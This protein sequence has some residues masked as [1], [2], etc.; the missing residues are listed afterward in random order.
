MSFSWRY[1][2]RGCSCCR[3]A[4]KRYWRNSVA[5][6]LMTGQP[7]SDSG[8]VSLPPF[9]PSQEI[10]LGLTLNMAKP[11]LR[12]LKAASLL[13][14]SLP[15]VL[16]LL[17]HSLGP[18]DPTFATLLFSLASYQPYAS[19]LRLVAYCFTSQTWFSLPLSSC[20]SPSWLL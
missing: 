15:K 14:S 11:L 1:N 3:N 18:G 6:E 19:S 16:P 13:V 9:R 7:L 17:P 10:P 5:F 8:D 4:R 12:V 2:E 20:S